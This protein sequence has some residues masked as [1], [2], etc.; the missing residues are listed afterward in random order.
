MDESW[1]REDAEEAP[2]AGPRSSAGGLAGGAGRRLRPHTDTIPKTLL[3]V[4]DDTTVL[5]VILGNLA[6][7]GLSAVLCFLLAQ[8]LPFNPEEVLWDW[9]QPL[10]LTQVYLLLAV[11]A[12]V[13]SRRYDALVFWQQFIG[14][15][16]SVMASWFRVQTP[17]I[18]G[19][20]R[21]SS[22]P[23]TPARR[24]SRRRCSAT[25]RRPRSRAP[26]TSAR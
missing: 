26:T 21:R 5:D 17:S 6:L 10:Y 14:L 25:R 20:I 13:S 7:F 24:R 4:G 8:R 11:R 1:H 12:L 2:G 16:Y 15:Y 23:R 19:P 22:R 18:S 3:S 9:R